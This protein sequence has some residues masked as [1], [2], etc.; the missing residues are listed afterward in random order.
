MQNQ[1][2]RDSQWQ[3]FFVV[4]EGDKPRVPLRAEIAYFKDKVVWV[5]F[6][7]MLCDFV[8][9]EYNSSCYHRIVYCEFKPFKDYVVDEIIKPKQRNKNREEFYS[10]IFGFAPMNCINQAWMRY[11]DF[12]FHIKTNQQYSGSANVESH[13]VRQFRVA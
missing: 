13:F 8:H 2:S 3:C 11:L 7:M 9:K 4:E 12:F 5:E 6:F 1:Q 10:F